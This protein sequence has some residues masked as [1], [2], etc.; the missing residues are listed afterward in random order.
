MTLFSQTQ[1]HGPDVVLLH[2]WGLHSGVWQDTAQALAQHYRV[3]RIDLPGYGGSAWSAPDSLETL[4]AYTLDSA[5]ARAVWIGWSLGGMLAL[6]AALNR[7][8]R[9]AGLILAASSPRFVQA[10]DWPGV[11]AQVLAQFSG[12]LQ[13]DF[14]GTLARF[15]TLQLRGSMESR[16]ALQQLRARLLDAG[17]PQMPALRDGLAMLAETDLR[18]RIKDITCRTLLICG[19]HDT[20]VPLAA[21]EAFVLLS[22]HAR[23]EC[24]RGA[25]H[26][27]F[28][29]HPHVFLRHVNAFLHDT[30]YSAQRT[31]PAPSR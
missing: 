18:S 29:S 7:P 30:F 8:A 1:G 24:I 17:T 6:Q 4:A 31:G 16:P 20:L 25:A 27:P 28:L 13:S 5:P 2:G 15:L 3:T 21:A 11:P 22:A 10:V 12:D 19:E 23:I 14:R 9:L 26:A